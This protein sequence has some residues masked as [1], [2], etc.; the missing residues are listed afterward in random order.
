M[1]EKPKPTTGEWTAD[2]DY[3][4]AGE[5]WPKG[6][7]IGRALDAIDAKRIAAAH[8]AALAAEREKREKAEQAANH[9][10]DISDSIA[11]ASQQVEQQLREQLATAVEAL[12]VIEIGHGV[13]ARIARAARAKV[14]EGK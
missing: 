14:K 8:N 9:N 5:I 1:S 11:R 3:I 12:K 13:D 4:Y 2:D 10:A 6:E 7:C